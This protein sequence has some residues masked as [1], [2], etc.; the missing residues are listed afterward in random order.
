MSV[1]VS[2]CV[3][4]CVCVCL[5]LCLC[6]CMYLSA[7]VSLFMCVCV[8]VGLYFLSICICLFMWYCLCVCVCGCRKAKQL[9][10]N[11]SALSDERHDVTNACF[12]NFLK[13]VTDWLL[14]WASRIKKLN[15]WKPTCN[16][17][18]KI[19]TRKNQLATCCLKFQLV[20]T[21]SQLVV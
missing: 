20:K 8:C 1:C 14:K 17:L 18:F 21:N 5:F 6:V 9:F 11:T 3:C 10:N 12:T 13:S 7:C 2:V 19:S 16:L 15:S 4:V